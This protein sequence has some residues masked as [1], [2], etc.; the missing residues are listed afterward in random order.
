PAGEQGMK[1]LMFQ[2]AKEK[3]DK[4]LKEKK[5]TEALGDLVVYVDDIDDDENWHGVYVSDMR[6][7]Q[8][9][10]I[11]VAKGG[12]MSADIDNMVVTIILNDGTLHNVD[13]QDNQVIRFQRYQL[14][15]PLRPPTRIDGDDVTTLDRGSMTQQQL[16][17]S[18]ARLGYDTP[19]GIVFLSEYHQRL[20]L[21]VGCF[22]LSLLGIPLGLQAGPGRRAA[23]IPL[24]LGCFVL[25][26][27][28]FTTGMVLVEDMVVPVI[29]G[30]WM[31]NVFFFILT[32]YVFLR[33][34]KEKTLFPESIHTVIL[35]LYEKLCQPVIALAGAV[36]HHV[37]SRRS[38]HRQTVEAA[39][40]S[41]MAQVNAN[42]TTKIYH[43]NT[44]E[45]YNCPQCTIFFI[46][47]KIA[48]ESGFTPCKYCK[49]QREE[50]NTS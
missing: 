31:P 6:N 22:I 32:V 35:F 9:P 49:A 11:T 8:Q 2:L 37:V 46:N 13:G 15:I 36:F 50:R 5:F 17:E 10:I 18:A 30:M 3:V 26:Y 34:D 16:L 14:H 43:F 39:A 4:G 23:G 1:L 24:G 25:Y 12:R 40:P 7:R 27:L 45:E 47:H 19:K 20:V 21:P 42:A 29:T 33:V 28:A 38:A 44:C 41:S 48:E